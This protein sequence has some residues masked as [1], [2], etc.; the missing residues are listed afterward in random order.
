VFLL[1]FALGSGALTV[2]LIPDRLRRV[3]ARILVLSS[4]LVPCV[5]FVIPVNEQ[6]LGTVGGVWVFVLF[7]GLLF[8]IH[9]L[10]TVLIKRPRGKKK[11]MLKYDEFSNIARKIKSMDN[12]HYI[13]VAQNV[14]A[15][16]M[17]SRKWKEGADEIGILIDLD[18]ETRK[19]RVSTTSTESPKDL[20]AR[21]AASLIRLVH[22]LILRSARSQ[23]WRASSGRSRHTQA[24]DGTAPN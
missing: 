7:F 14:F 20:V 3:L 12:Q 19:A 1:L 24:S 15:E 2:L 6:S 10:L 4:F 21:R 18:N 22:T 11:R 17:V 5:W 8:A 13:E 16:A 23:S 9:W